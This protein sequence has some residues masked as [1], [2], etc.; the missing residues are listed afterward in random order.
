[1]Q[2]VFGLQLSKIQ[3]QMIDFVY[4]A[5]I[6]L[7]SQDVDAFTRLAEN[8]FQLFA[9]F[10]TDISKDRK[11]ETCALVHFTGILCIYPRVLAYRQHMVSHLLCLPWPG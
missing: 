4:A 11:M 6:E 8:L 10:W 3:T 1:M 5:A 7:N 9:M 2:E